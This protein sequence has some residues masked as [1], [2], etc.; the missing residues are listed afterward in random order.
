MRRNTRNSWC[1][2]VAFSTPF[3]HGSTPRLDDHS[4]LE[5]STKVHLDIVGGQFGE[6][7]VLEHG[8]QMLQ[9]GAD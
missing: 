1:T 8:S 3:L 9:K 6:F 7:G 2:V 4:L 5:P